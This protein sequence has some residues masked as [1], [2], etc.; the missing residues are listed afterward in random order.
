MTDVTRPNGDTSD[1]SDKRHESDERKSASTDTGKG[2]T[3]IGAG[4]G[5][6][7]DRRDLTKADDRREATT[8]TPIPRQTDRPADRQ[9]DRQID[10]QNDRQ[11]DTTAPVHAPE[12]APAPAST[13]AD[14]RHDRLDAGNGSLLPHDES[15]KFNLRL[16]HAVTGF[17]D[18]PRSA[19]EEAAHV[20]EEVADRLTQAVT[21]RRDTL[22]SSWEAKGS[23]DTEQLRLALRDYRELTERL[24]HI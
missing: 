2:S 18:E 8:V 13:A 16:Q 4:T 23:D 10:R 17:V 15:D 19:V 14:K 24:L 6:G 22:H 12:P 5:A 21:K 20:L 11:A 7:T 3:D 1:T 9:I